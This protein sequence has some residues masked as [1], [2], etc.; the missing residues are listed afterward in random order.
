M[1]SWHAYLSVGEIRRGDVVLAKDVD[2][3]LVGEVIRFFDNGSSISAEVKRFA[4]LRNDD[5]RD[6]ITSNASLEFVEAACIRV[7]LTWA[8]RRKGVITALV[9]PVLM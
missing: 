2:Q 3:Y 4:P 7:N 5:L 6:W 1:V 9:P 8:P